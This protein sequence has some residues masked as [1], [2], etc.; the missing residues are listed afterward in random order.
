MIRND[1]TEI[2]RSPG[3]PDC[4]QTQTQIL[5]HSEHEVMFNACRDYTE[6]MEEHTRQNNAPSTTCPS[7]MKSS[8]HPMVIL[9]AISKG[10]GDNGKKTHLLL[11][12]SA[13]SR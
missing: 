2:P 11:F 8:I 13:N 3:R 12:V 5:R 1:P 7:R 10:D 6:S 4:P 9:D